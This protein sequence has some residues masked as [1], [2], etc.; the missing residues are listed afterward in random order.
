MKTYQTPEIQLIDLE[1]ASVMT[2]SNAS[3]SYQV[4]STTTTQ[5]MQSSKRN[6]IDWDKYMDY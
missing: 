6:S 4:N 5:Q 2:I 1:I 3:S